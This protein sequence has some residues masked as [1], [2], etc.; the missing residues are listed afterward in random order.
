[1]K[2]SCVIKKT[3]VHL[4]REWK[5]TKKDKPIQGIE[6]LSLQWHKGTRDDKSNSKLTSWRFKF[7]T[8]GV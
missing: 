6:D 1:M 8:N 3:F 4:I 7:L 5:G 2:A